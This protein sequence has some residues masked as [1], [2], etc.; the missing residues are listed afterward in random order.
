MSCAGVVKLVDA[1]DS[2]SPGPCVR[3]GSIPTSG[4]NDFKGLDR[5][6]LSPFFDENEAQSTH[7]KMG[8]STE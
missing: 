5:V 7:L 6:R 2:K 4:I 8:S 3:V 1:G